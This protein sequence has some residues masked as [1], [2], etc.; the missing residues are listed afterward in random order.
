MLRMSTGTMLAGFAGAAALLLASAV[1]AQEDCPSGACQAGRGYR[2]PRTTMCRTCNGAS[3]KGC[4]PAHQP[5]DLF[6]NY[7]TGPSNCPNQ[8]A[9]MYPAPY[10]TPPI[11]G[12]TWYTYQP[13]LPHEHMYRHNRHYY[14][15]YNYG[16]G[17]NRTSVSWSYNP[18]I[19]GLGYLH[20]RL[21]VPR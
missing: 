2:A 1:Q 5:V 11:V 6:Y 9:G 17:L 20:R 12:H 7:Y 19:A 16:R 10:P 3:T 18:I 14:Q 13:L 4:D 8:T 15:Y 21:E